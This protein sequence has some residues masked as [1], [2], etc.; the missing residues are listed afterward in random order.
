MACSSIWGP[1]MVTYLQIWGWK[2]FKNQ[3]S[4][5]GSGIFALI[6]VLLL[7]HSWMWSEMCVALPCWEEVN[8]FVLESY[9][10]GSWKWCKKAFPRYPKSTK[11]VVGNS[12]YHFATSL[13]KVLWKNLNLMLSS[14]NEFEEHHRWKVIMCLLGSSL[15]LPSNLGMFNGSFVVIGGSWWMPNR[16]IYQLW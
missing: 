11:L 3:S 2:D 4:R 16:I 12:I 8:N 10:I 5:N 13:I 6:Y 7:Y 15:T 9:R 14:I 1:I